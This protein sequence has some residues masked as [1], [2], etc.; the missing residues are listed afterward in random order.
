MLKAS[1]QILLLRPSSPCG[2]HK[3][4]WAPWVPACGKAAWEPERAEAH[5]K[6]DFVLGCKWQTAAEQACG[7]TS[8]GIQCCWGV[9]RLA[10]KV[11]WCPAQF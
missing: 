1:F 8:D 10:N 6:G 7:T 5:S 11:I 3:S 2:C 9:C 4:L